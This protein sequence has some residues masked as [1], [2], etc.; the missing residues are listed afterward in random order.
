MN[1]ITTKTLMY[2]D[3]M[4][5]LK[6]EHIDELTGCR[7]Y[8]TEQLSKLHKIIT[9]RQMSVSLQDIKEMIENPKL[10]DV[11]L[12][13]KE[14]EVIKNI[15]SEE[16]KLAKIKRFSNM[17]VNGHNY[18]Y[19]PIMKELPEV[20]V[21]SMRQVVDTYDAFFY[22]YPDIMAK[23]MKKAGCK[24]IIPKYC[25][26]IYHDEEFMEKNIDVEICEAIAEMKTD[27]KIIKFKTIKKVEKAICVF[28]KG[29]YNKI[30]EAY[31]FIFKWMEENNYRVLDN[32]RESYIDGIWNK[33]NEE[34]WLTEIQVPI[35]FRY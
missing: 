19:K 16:R 30:R 27:T 12:K 3:E 4:G 15:R 26:N 22:L 21:A 18:E 35:E 17:F 10:L 32:P 6:P 25:F 28:H 8:T 2:Y 20:I 5:L 29:P 13:L 23:E 14:H 31:T 9:L 33:E 11:F 34:D 1:K 7:Y 24:A